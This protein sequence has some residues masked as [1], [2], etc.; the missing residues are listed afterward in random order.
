MAGYVRQSS[1][2]IADALTIEAVD[3][4]NEFNDLVA[5][6]SNTSGHK[7]DGTAAE[8][9]VISV[10]GDSGVATLLAQSRSTAGG[11]DAVTTDIK[12]KHLLCRYGV[13][14]ERDDS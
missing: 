5:A 12:Y 4:N 7:H 10:L 11:A 14:S 3:L 13:K 8:G 1:A 2:E 9:P 6:F